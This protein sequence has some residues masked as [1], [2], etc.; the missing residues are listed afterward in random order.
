[1]LLLTL[2]RLAL[3]L[4]PLRTPSAIVTALGWA[5]LVWVLV[6]GERAYSFFLRATLTATLW[7]LLLFAFISLFRTLPV[8]PLPALKWH[9]RLLARIRVALFQLVT[10]AFI[11]LVLLVCA[12]SLKLMMLG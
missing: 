5:A 2:N 7:A 9:E 12:I 8:P 11:A 3:R 1:M 6:N 10:F 4:L